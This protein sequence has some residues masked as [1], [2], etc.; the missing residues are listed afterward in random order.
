M[1]HCN[2]V[3]TPTRVAFPS[4]TAHTDNEASPDHRVTH[5]GAGASFTVFVHA[6]PPFVTRCGTSSDGACALSHVR[7]P[8]AVV[9]SPHA[10]ILNAPVT[11]LATTP[12]EVDVSGWLQTNDAVEGVACGRLHALLR[13]RASYTASCRCVGAG[14][15]GVMCA[16]VHAFV[17]RHQ[18]LVEWR[19][20]L[21]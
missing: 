20:L 5:V 16:F 7:A 17:L 4:P 2:D 14:G 9:A 6:S 13:S 1:G 12:T 21:A 3:T 8:L 11:R 18:V 10:V 19:R 15:A